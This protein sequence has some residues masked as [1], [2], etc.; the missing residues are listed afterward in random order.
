MTPPSAVKKLSLSPVTDVE[1]WRPARS[2]QARD[3]DGIEG[4]QSEGRVPAH[5][6]IVAP[7]DAAIVR[8]PDRAAEMLVE[9]AVLVI[10]RRHACGRLQRQIQVR[11]RDKP[12]RVGMHEHVLV[13]MRV[14]VAPIGRCVPAVEP[15]PL[16]GGERPSHGN[17]H[18]A[19]I[20]KE[21]Q[22]A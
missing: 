4:W 22:I 11:T 12:V 7:G 14:V 13:G 19:L 21:Q 5:A 17:V 1:R 20:G 3:V 15:M 16:D 6:A 10:R 2:S 8:H 9:F 18:G